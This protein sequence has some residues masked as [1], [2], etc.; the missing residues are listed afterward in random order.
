MVKIA[1]NNTVKIP[2]D[3]MVK[4][5]NDNMVKIHDDNMVKIPNDNMVKIH[6]DNMVK[7]TMITH[8]NFWIQD[9]LLDGKKS[10]MRSALLLG[11]VEVCS[12]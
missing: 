7:F 5:P 9:F 1:N 6:D 2:N 10:I 11:N 4:I 3:N 12:P 8:V